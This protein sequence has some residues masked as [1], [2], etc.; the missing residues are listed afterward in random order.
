MTRGV[1]WRLQIFLSL[2]SPKEGGKEQGGKKKRRMKKG[3]CEIVRQSDDDGEKD[4]GAEE[5]LVA[6]WR[7]FDQ[8]DVIYIENTYPT[9]NFTS[10]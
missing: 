4:G 2:S 1:E 3:K 6:P 5:K 8:Y 9:S 7:C 10:N